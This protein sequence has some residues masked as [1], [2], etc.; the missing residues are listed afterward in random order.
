MIAIEYSDDRHNQESNV[1]EPEV[2][3]WIE[4]NCKFRQESSLFLFPIEYTVV[5]QGRAD[6]FLSTPKGTEDIFCQP[7]SVAEVP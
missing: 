5:G 2:W 3:M 6:R 7:A 4:T 1:G